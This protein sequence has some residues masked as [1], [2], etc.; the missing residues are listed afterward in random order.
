MDTL[1]KKRSSAARQG[2]RLGSKRRVMGLWRTPMEGVVGSNPVVADVRGVCSTAGHGLR[3][4]GARRG[5][6]RKPSEV[7]LCW[8]NWSKWHGPD[9]RRA[10]RPWRARG[11]GQGRLPGPC[12]CSP[13][14]PPRP[15]RRRH[16]G[17]SQPVG[18][19]P[20]VPESRSGC[21][22]ASRASRSAEPAPEAEG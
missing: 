14:T 5:L 21:R 20:S 9:S 16:W 8:S 1:T 19:R 3:R 10:R 12:A 6:G 7:G 11:R 2:G 15:S 4:G 18:L 17:S 13:V 22:P